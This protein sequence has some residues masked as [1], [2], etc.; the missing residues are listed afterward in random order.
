MG[1]RLG[2][3]ILKVQ[4][5]ELSWRQKLIFGCL[6]IQQKLK[7]LDAIEKLEGRGLKKENDAVRAQQPKKHKPFA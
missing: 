5:M 7:M 4:Q 6:D 1:N 2:K 3:E